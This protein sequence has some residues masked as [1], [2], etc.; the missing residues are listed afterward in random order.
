MLVELGLTADCLRRDLLVIPLIVSEEGLGGSGVAYIPLS[1][2]YHI[3]RL[4]RFCG[5]APGHDL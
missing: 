2:V 4:R 5:L 3:Q 1:A